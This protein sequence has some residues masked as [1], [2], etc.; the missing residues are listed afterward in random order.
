MWCGKNSYPQRAV[1][2]LIILCVIFLSRFCFAS[3]EIANVRHWTA[4]DHTRI[5]L[6]VSAEP[7]YEV[8]QGDNLLILTFKKAYL[9]KEITPEVVLNKPGIK[10]LIFNAINQEDIKIEIYLDEHEKAEVFKLKKI[11]DRPDRVVVDIT[12]KGQSVQEEVL[13]EPQP[14]IKRK[15]IIVIDPGH[16]GEDPGAVSKRNKGVYE[17]DVVLAISREIKKAIDK[18]PDFRAVLTR[19]GDYYVSFNKRLQIAR[20]LN[21]SLFI[22]VHADAARNKK[23][24]GSSVYSLSTGGASSEAARLLASNENLADIVGGVPGSEGKNEFD[25]IILNMFQTNTI[26]LSRNYA[27]VLIKHLNRINC[28]KYDSVQEA[29]FHVLK[30]PDIPAVLLETAYLSN[31]DEERLLRSKDFQRRIA[32]A[33]ASS[34][35]EYFVGTASVYEYV[36]TKKEH[37]EEKKNGKSSTVK[38]TIK[39]GDTFFTVAKNHN[40]TV[41]ELLK[42]NNMKL[43]DK[44]FVGQKILV[45]SSGGKAIASRNVKKYTVKKGDTL[46]SLAKNHAITVDELCDLN[47][48]K[49]DAT[50][51]LGQ[52]INLP[53]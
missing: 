18:N 41:A 19:S 39:R 13:A 32:A 20:D 47:N 46:Y 14:V 8:E 38:Y 12:L 21:A 10:K 6:D 48:M 51:Y 28:L 2:L 5:V 29:P 7:V 50:L 23:A 42:L 34:V 44:I 27:E 36:T 31:P 43:H 33:V 16:G 53:R 49:S 37:K 40:T 17:K 30:L 4:P 1:S 35:S 24:K 11:Q 52:V 25:P 22:S 45:P 9:N 3:L 26:N 15:R